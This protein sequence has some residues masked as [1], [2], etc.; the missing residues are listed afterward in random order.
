MEQRSASRRWMTRDGGQGA[1][2]MIKIKRNLPLLLAAGS[3]CMAI[4]LPAAHAQVLK[5]TQKQIAP[6]FNPDNGKINPGVPVQAPSSA[7]PGSNDASGSGAA[8]SNRAPPSDTHAASNEPI[9]TPQQ[10]L[11]ALLAPDSP[12][13]AIGQVAMPPQGDAASAKTATGDAP[14]GNA[15]A[16]Q[17]D[18]NSQSGDG[19]GASGGGGG[20]TT[21]K[22]PQEQ[23]AQQAARQT[24]PN[25]PIGSTTQTL[26]A[27]FSERNDILGRLPTMAWPVRLNDEQRRQVFQAVMSDNGKEASDID[28]LKPADQ[29][30]A[31]QALADMHPLPQSLAQFDALR[32]YQYLKAKN[33]V[34]LVTPATRT[35]VDVIT[36]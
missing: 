32:A 18:N 19:K 20:E 22:S 9:P 23:S 16:Q 14:A 5:D 25:K 31:K 10:A 3:L 13:A 30:P 1:S 8:V 6:G 12:D 17:A 4:A 27:K 35:V 36:N 21:G 24:S 29:L 7:P 11:A 28:S 34:V 15:K 33:K 26:P 2:P